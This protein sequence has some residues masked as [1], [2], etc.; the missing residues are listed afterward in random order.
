MKETTLD[1]KKKKCL[2]ALKTL[3]KNWP[4]DWE[5]VVSG[6]FGS[7]TVVSKESNIVT[8]FDGFSRR[9]QDFSSSD[10]IVAEFDNLVVSTTE[11]D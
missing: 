5:L 8:R 9:I 4:E 3:N 6:G 7:L 10:A 11:F 1:A 2:A